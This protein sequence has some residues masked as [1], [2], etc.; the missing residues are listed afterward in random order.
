MLPQPHLRVSLGERGLSRPWA[1]GR[2]A[3]EVGL[4]RVDVTHVPFGP[5]TS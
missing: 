2:L 5:Q 1:G 3:P 4:A